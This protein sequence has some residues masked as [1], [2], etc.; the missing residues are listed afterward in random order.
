MVCAN[1]F[2]FALRQLETTT[3]VNGWIVDLMNFGCA[4]RQSSI[5]E[6][7]VNL[8]CHHVKEQD[9]LTTKTA[10]AVLTS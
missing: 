7:N 9:E 3:Q 6:K 10:E 4:K 5:V 1:I 2:D 8:Q